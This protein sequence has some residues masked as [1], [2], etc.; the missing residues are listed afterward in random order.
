M[1]RVI[2]IVSTE[3]LKLQAIFVVILIPVYVR[4]LLPLLPLT[5]ALSQHSFPIRM[6]KFTPSKNRYFTD[7]FERSQFLHFSTPSVNVRFALLISS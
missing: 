4:P 7:S 3:S 2:S 6:V 5:L 1:L